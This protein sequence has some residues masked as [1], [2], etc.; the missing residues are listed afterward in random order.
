[1]SGKKMAF[2]GRRWRDHSAALVG[3]LRPIRGRL[4]HETQKAFLIDTGIRRAWV[5]KRLVT[6]DEARGVFFVPSA[7]AAQ[8]VLD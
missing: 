3:S 1:M 6:H 7:L 8:K 2:S 4:A 5:P